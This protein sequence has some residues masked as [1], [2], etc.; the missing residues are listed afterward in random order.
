MVFV[1][2][3]RISKLQWHSFSVTSIS[4]VDEH[5][6]SVIVKCQGS[7][8]NSLFEMINTELKSGSDTTNAIAIAVEGPYGPAST[9]FLGY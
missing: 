3:P 7:W 2:I 1:K 4:S 9:N 8:T 6:M 5:T